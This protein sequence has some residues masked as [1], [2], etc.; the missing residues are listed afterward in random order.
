MHRARKLITGAVLA[1]LATGVAVPLPASA[2]TATGQ[3][4]QTE[5]TQS[6][7]TQPQPSQSQP[8]RTGP[9]RP[10]TGLEGAAIPRDPVVP[11]L[12]DGASR[13]PPMGFNNWNSF[14]CDVTE[15]LIMATADV[16][17]TSGLKDAGYQYVNIDDC[18]STRERDAD[19]NLVPDPVKFP[20]GIKHVA[21]YV[22]SRGLLLGLYADAGTLTCAGYPGSLGH[23]QRDAAA[24]AS[25][26]VDYL[27]Y[28]NCYNQG[29]DARQRYTTMR[30]ALL[31]TGRRIV[32]SVCEWGENQPWTWARDVGHLWRTTPDITDTWGSVVDI[33]HRNAPLNDAAGP[34]GWNDPDMLEVGNGGM[35]TTEY[36]SHFTLWAQMAAP[37]LIGADLRVATP[38]TMA[39][40][41]N[42]GLIAVNQDPLGVQARPVSSSG[43]RHVLSKPLADGDRSVVLFNEGGAEAVIGTSLQAIGLPGGGSTAT[44]LWTGATRRFTGAITARV[45]AHGVVAMRIRADAAPPAGA[46][47]LVGGSSG[48]CLDLPGGRTGVQVALWDCNG[49]PNQQFRHTASGELRVQGEHCLEA[50]AN[51]VAEGTQ[52]VTW[53][54]NGG[55]NQRWTRQASGQLV[56]AGSGLCLDVTAGHL[57]ENN[58]NGSP[59]ALWRCNSGPNQRWSRQ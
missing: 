7:P 11:M 4:Q 48:R 53:Q 44:D 23:E 9:A 58:L 34:G 22:H 51:G 32:F 31:A 15:E 13:V 21:D 30:D 41:L 42:R 10:A 47:N 3:A 52:V 36:R 56:N 43:T 12:D 45:P 57:P 46:T 20:K 6:Q 17:V 16:F 33:F 50:F 26:G 54:C 14:G 1:L 24:F 35:T 19:G 38:E 39:I 29:I 37:L 59:I 27:K 8:T 28:D 55:A 5:P 40:Y 2:T 18:W 25:W 49:G